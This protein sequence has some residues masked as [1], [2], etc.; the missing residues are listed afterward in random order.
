LLDLFLHGS[1]H[2]RRAQVHFLAGRRSA[3]D[4]VRAHAF[5]NSSTLRLSFSREHSLLL[6]RF[7]WS[8][9]SGPGGSWNHAEDIINERSRNLEKYQ[10]VEEATFDLYTAVRNAY[11]QSRARAIKE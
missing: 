8:I 11:L 2:V 4:E 1:H 9:R 5:E 10:G 3:G 6:G 7:Y